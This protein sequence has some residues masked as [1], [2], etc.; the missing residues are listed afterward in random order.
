MERKLATVVL[1]L[2]AVT[3]GIAT[4]LRFMPQVSPARQGSAAGQAQGPAAQNVGGMELTPIQQV[5]QDLI[6]WSQA[7]ALDDMGGAG[8]TQFDWYSLPDHVKDARMEVIRATN[9]YFRAVLTEAQQDHYDRTILDPKGHPLPPKWES[10]RLKGT[11]VTEVLKSTPDQNVRAKQILDKFRSAN[12]TIWGHGRKNGGYVKN[13]AEL[14]KD[15]RA[16]LS[17]KQLAEFDSLWRGMMSE[18]NVAKQQ[19]QAKP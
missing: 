4:T 17:P 8:G 6:T 3:A 15:F 12:S 10:M 13:H 2:L 7:N 5:L 14:V 19:A 11:L 9:L 16:M 1:A 18:I